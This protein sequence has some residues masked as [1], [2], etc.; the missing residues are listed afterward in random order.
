MQTTEPIFSHALVREVSRSLANCELTHLPRQPFDLALAAQQHQAYVDALRTTGINVTVLPEEPALPD[1]AFVEDMAVMLDELIVICRPGCASRQREVESILPVLEKVRP[2]ARIEA[3]GTLDGGDVLTIARTL[4]VGLSERT[5]REGLRQLESIVSRHGY[6]VVPVTIDGCL[7]LK[8]A[9]TQV[10]PHV[11]LA[12][13]QWVDLAPFADFEVLTVPA[14]EPWGAN[15]LRVNGVLLTAVSAPKTTDLLRSRGLDVRPLEISELQKAEAGLTCLSLLYG[16]SRWWLSAADAK[17][18][19]AAISSRNARTQLT[20]ERLFAYFS[21]TSTNA[22]T[23]G[24]DP[25][26]QTAPMVSGSKPG[27]GRCRS[28]APS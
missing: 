17:G 12:S 16:G 3:P 23:S 27:S 25:L 20:G 19:L 11:V 14:S 8:S 22:G 4:F 7:H 18:R 26:R 1:A 15:T 2:L 6:R 13:P 21:T 10:A 24:E 28:P 9:L 5:N